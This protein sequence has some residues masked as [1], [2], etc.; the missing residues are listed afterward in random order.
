MAGRQAGRQIGTNLFCLPSHWLGSVANIIQAILFYLFFAGNLF[1]SKSI[2][3]Q[4]KQQ[5]HEHGNKSRNSSVP[6]FCLARCFLV[7]LSSVDIAY[8]ILTRLSLHKF[9]D[10]LKPIRVRSFANQNAKGDTVCEDH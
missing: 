6:H 8:I 9:G 3:E 7:P 10:D 4:L 5:S 2:T 1:S